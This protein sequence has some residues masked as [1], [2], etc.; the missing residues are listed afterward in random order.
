MDGFLSHIGEMRDT[1]RLAAIWGRRPATV[2]DA[3]HVKRCTRLASHT[4][5]HRTIGILPIPQTGDGTVHQVLWDARGK[6]PEIRWHPTPCHTASA[7]SHHT[8]SCRHLFVPPHLH[9]STFLED[10]AH[11][12]VPPFAY[13]TVDAQMGAHAPL[14]RYESVPA[15]RLSPYCE[16]RLAGTEHA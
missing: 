3:T 10:G 2:R 12:H 16:G 13:Q 4:L 8:T 5:F 15:V 1:T 11:M 6:T 14:Y 7:A 9:N